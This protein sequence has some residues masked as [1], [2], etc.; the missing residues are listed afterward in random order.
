MSAP[1]DSQRP[2]E[3]PSA[4]RPRWGCALLTAGGRPDDLA[5]AIASLRAQTGTGADIVVVGNG[6][7]PTGLPDGVRSVHL[8][9]D[10]GVTAGRNAGAAAAGGDLLFFLDDDA[11]LVAAGTLARLQARFDADPALGAVGLRVDPR[12]PGGALRRDWT[13]RLRVGDRFRSS[14][15]TA[16]WEGAVAVRRSAFEAAGGWPDHFRFIHEGVALG[17]RI[18]DGGWTVRYA[19]DLA[20]LHPSDV[21][22]TGAAAHRARHYY[23]ARNRVWLAR[24]LLPLALG[25]PYV[26]AFALRTARSRDAL[27]GYRD[28][29][30]QPAG[31]RRPLR[32]STLWRMLRAGRPPVL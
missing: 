9:T 29:F 3:R 31:P 16:V 15:V 14:A 7:A 25:V 4:V 8:P 17:W 19:G 1:H 23:A 13:P 18:M 30:S 21:T 12:E 5:A 10:D 28:G 20:A 32:A 24:E 26:T 27:R 2:P 11:S 6:W 22:T